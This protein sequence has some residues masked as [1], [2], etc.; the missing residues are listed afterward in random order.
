L[1][2]HQD[3]ANYENQLA[4]LLTKFVFSPSPNLSPNHFRKDFVIFF[5]RNSGCQV[6]SFPLKA[7]LKAGFRLWP[8]RIFHIA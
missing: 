4:G 8:G 2:Q 3:I 1:P 5:Y 7:G 6:Q